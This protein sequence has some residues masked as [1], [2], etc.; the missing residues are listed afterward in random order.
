MRWGPRTLDLDLILH[1]ET[2]V[3]SESLQVPHPRLGERRFVLKP[4]LE[5]WPEATTPDG[6]RIADLLAAVDSQ[7]LRRV[8]KWRPGSGAVPGR[9]GGAGFTGRGG[10]WVV[11][12]G[13][14]LVTA[15]VALLAGSGTLTVEGSW[16]LWVGRILLAAG[17]VQGAAGVLSLGSSLT[18]YPEPLAGGRLV[19]R[20]IYRH[21]RHPIYGGVAI[22]LAGA[23]LHAASLPGLLL[24]GAVAMFFWS[25]AG[26]EERR[27]VDRYPGYPAYRDRTRARI[28]PWLL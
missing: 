2:A 27:L 25:K 3:A 5:V 9:W 1:G 7:R 19:V 18:P 23:A 13:A 12:Q 11:G 26:F 16:H 22:G 14:L 10:W 24:A 4:L 28:I 8:G 17:V 20:G 15:A 6:T 21:V